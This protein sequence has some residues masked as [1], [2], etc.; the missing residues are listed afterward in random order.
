MALRDGPLDE[1]ADALAQEVGGPDG[2]YGIECVWLSG[3]AV[4]GEWKRWTV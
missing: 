1:R 2:R 3:L 4:Q